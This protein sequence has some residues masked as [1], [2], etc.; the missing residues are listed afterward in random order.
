MTKKKWNLVLV[1]FSWRDVRA[2][3]EHTTKKGK[4]FETWIKLSSDGAAELKF[5]RLK[6]GRP[7]QRQREKE[8]DLVMWNVIHNTQ[9]QDTG[10]EKKLEELNWKQDL[11]EQWILSEKNPQFFSF[12]S[13]LF[14]FT[15]HIS[16]ALP[17]L[18]LTFVCASTIV[19][20]AYLFH[21]YFSPLT[22]LSALGVM[23]SCVCSLAPHFL[24][25]V[26]ARDT[27]IKVP[28][29]RLGDSSSRG[30]S[31]ERSRTAAA[32]SGRF[33]S[34]RI[35]DFLF[36]SVFVF[37]FFSVVHSH[38]SLICTAVAAAAASS[39]S[40]WIRYGAPWATR[41]THFFSSGEKFNLCCTDIRRTRARRIPV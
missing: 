2:H 21:S 9:A 3:S 11:R 24:S 19:F 26:M 32:K 13:R 39:Y 29:S 22:S 38:S 15:A 16:L 37:I 12:S 1:D 20:F 34:A 27:L 41:R 31:W 17:P 4:L 30:R 14:R 6:R 7:A 10:S 8:W 5:Y 36:F 18:S 35:L 33:A 23:L 28:M 40:I 25:M